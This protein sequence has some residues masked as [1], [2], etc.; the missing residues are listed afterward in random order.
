MVHIRIPRLQ[1]H[2]E[3][4]IIQDS[5]L[6]CFIR[7]VEENFDPRRRP[8]RSEDYDFFN[9]KPAPQQNRR[10][11]TKETDLD[12]DDGGIYKGRMNQRERPREIDDTRDTKIDLPIG[13]QDVQT[14]DEENFYGGHAGVCRSTDDTL[15]DI[16]LFISRKL[17]VVLF[18]LPPINLLPNPFPIHGHVRLKY[19][20][21]SVFF[22]NSILSAII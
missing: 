2:M 21:P 10:G 3:V 6:P 22:H 11:P 12:R 17:H 15:I 5:E 14:V 18:L 20:M 9:Y 16:F 4:W 8:V 19:D 13:Y 7:T 1:L